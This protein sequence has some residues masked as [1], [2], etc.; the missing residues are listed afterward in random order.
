MENKMLQRILGKIVILFAFIYLGGCAVQEQGAA[1]SGV[2]PYPVDEYETLRYWLLQDKGYLTAKWGEE[3]CKYWGSLGTPCP[4]CGDCKHPGVDYGTNGVYENVYAVASGEIVGKNG[5]PTGKICI[6]NRPTKVTFC[7]LHF[8]SFEVTSGE[9]QQGELIGKT[10]KTGVNSI[11][12]HFEAR[13]GEKVSAACCYNDTINPIEAA[14]RA[15]GKAITPTQPTEPVVPTFT[16]TP[17]PTDCIAF[18]SNDGNIWTINPDGTGEQKL[19]EGGGYSEPIWSPDGSKIAFIQTVNQ[20]DKQVSQIGIFELGSKETHILVEP[21]PTPFVFLGNYYNFQN[22]RWSADGRFLFFL[23]SDY[24]RVQGDSIRMLDLET[25]EQNKH[26][27]DYARSFDISHYDGR[28]V[29]T[30]FSNGDPVGQGLDVA[31]ADGSFIQHLVP[32]ENNL[33]VNHPRWAPD[34]S[35]IAFFGQGTKYGTGSIVVI[36]SGNEYEHIFS[37]G[38]PTIWSA[39]L[40]WSPNMDKLVFEAEGA[41]KILVLQDSS[42]QD[43]TS[44]FDPDWVPLSIIHPTNTD[45]IAFVS[46]RDGNNEIYLMELAGTT[47]VSLTNL[48]NN[49][50]DDQGPVWSP[51][52]SRIAFESNRNGNYEIYVMEITDSTV[53][54]LTN[55]TNHLGGDGSPAWSPDGTLISFLSSRCD[56]CPDFDGVGLYVMNANGSAVTDSSLWVYGPGW[57][58]WP[59]TPDGRISFPSENEIRIMNIDGTDLVSIMKAD[60]NIEYHSYAWSQDKQR[61]AFKA[62]GYD[63]GN[64]LG[65]FVANVDGSNRIRI[66]DDVFLNH[67]GSGVFYLEDIVWSPNDKKIVFDGYVNP[68]DWNTLHSSPIKIFVAN[69]DGSNLTRPLDNPGND[70]DPVWS[71]ESNRI[72]FV[73]DRDGNDE[74]YVMNVDGSN[75]INLTN[76]PA[77]DWDPVWSPVPGKVISCSSTTSPSTT[78]SKVSFAASPCTRTAASKPSPTCSK[79]RSTTATASATRVSSARATC[80]G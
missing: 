6:Y 78:P 68:F 39:D 76:N 69:A 11:H 77:D 48:T 1:T 50:A 46:D 67:P 52:G 35:Q 55:L 25:R 30:V 73:S 17:I 43:L 63:D 37:I 14:I 3:D 41:L 7:Y 9:V 79:A 31:S 80:N 44:G 62:W 70:T 21:E 20:T 54:S 34:S 26:F 71:P 10:G 18:I 2:T 22:P 23:A 24:S 42:V 51:D 72:A 61:I 65:V 57:A 19:T 75:Q 29:Y 15:R 49:P 12:L 59:W 40:S 45:R 66:L 28:I 36:G 47:V 38:I 13:A 8:L 33:S 27:I 4:N 74:I 56:K 5:G 53:V 16:A 58:Y 32:I 64:K 60:S